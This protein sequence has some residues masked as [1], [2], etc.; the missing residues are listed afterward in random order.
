MVAAHVAVMDVRVA[1]V[2]AAGMAA[3]LVAA[4]DV[5][6][7]QAAAAVGLSRRTAA[8]RTQRRAEECVAAGRTLAAV[9]G[10]VGSTAETARRPPASVHSR[11]AETA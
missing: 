5:A 10:S 2:A 4:A 1:D 9:G 6:V 8:W 3:A 7:V 11:S